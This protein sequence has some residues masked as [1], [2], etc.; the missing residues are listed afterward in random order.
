MIGSWDY[1]TT[2]LVFVCVVGWVL[3]REWLMRGLK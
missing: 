1:V 2:G 3:V